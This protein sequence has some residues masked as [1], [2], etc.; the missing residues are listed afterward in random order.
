MTSGQ[1]KRMPYNSFSCD[2]AASVN[3]RLIISLFPS[4]A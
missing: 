1:A 2:E 4:A 3:R